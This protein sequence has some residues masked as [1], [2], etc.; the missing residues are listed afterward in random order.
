[1]KKVTLLAVGSLVLIC[2]VVCAGFAA[3]PSDFPIKAKSYSGIP[4]VSGGIGL[5]EREALTRMS[6]DYNLK[7]SFA[8]TSGNYLGDVPIVIRDAGGKVVLEAVSE[9]PWFLTKLPPGKYNVTA[10]L[11]GQIQQRSVQV[12]AGGQSQLSFFWKG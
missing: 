1:M 12:S 2:A 5:D 8:V 4:Y 9:G 11:M 7:L 3:D 10:K 6:P